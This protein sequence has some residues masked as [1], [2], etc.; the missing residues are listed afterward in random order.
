MPTQ[1]R[2]VSKAQSSYLKEFWMAHR[3][4]ALISQPYDFYPKG[5]LLLNLRVEVLPHSVQLEKSLRE[6]GRHRARKED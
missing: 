6:H 3:L 5:N 4:W 1:L 2:E